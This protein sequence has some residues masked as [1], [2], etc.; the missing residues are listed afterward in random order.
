[1]QAAW[2]VD[3]SDEEESGSDEDDDG[4]VLDREESGLA[5]QMRTNEFDLDDDQGSLNLRY[6][7]DE[8]ENDSVMMV[9]DIACID[10]ILSTLSLAYL[11]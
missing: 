7:D 10:I 2:I 9:S 3:D 5:G 4:M 8:T 11:Y 6:S 1:M